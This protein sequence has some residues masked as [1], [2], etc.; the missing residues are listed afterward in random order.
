MAGPHD[1]VDGGD[2]LLPGSAL[3]LQEFP[4][5]GRQPVTP[6]AAFAVFLQPAAG[7]QATVLQPEQDGVQRPDAEADLSVGTFLNQLADVVSMARPAF[8]QSQNQQLGTALFRSRLKDM[9]Q[10]IILL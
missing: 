7:D 3:G 8:E 2:K 9:L 6:A 5:G 1:S 4:P 10:Q